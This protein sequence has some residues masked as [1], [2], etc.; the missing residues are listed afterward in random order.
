MAR[1]FGEK[2]QDGDP[3]VAALTTATPAAAPSTMS[4]RSK[5]A[6]APSGSETA[7][8]ESAWPET[9][10]KTGAK[11]SGPEARSAPAEPATPADVSA[12]INGLL[13]RLVRM[14]WVIHL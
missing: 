1:L 10:P 3:N 12:L 7:W 13:E 9:R 6:A 14:T 2:S 4:T 11:A 5:A 8:P